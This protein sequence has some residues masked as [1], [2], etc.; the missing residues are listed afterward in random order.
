MILI[1]DN[2][3]SFTYNLYQQVAFT[4]VHTEVITN[5]Y[6]KFELIEKYNPEK[7]I[8]SSGP[9]TP[10][11][12][13]ISISVVKSYYTKI[14]IL[15]VC[16]GHQVIGVVFGSDIRKA[17][18]LLYGKTSTIHFEK[19]KL[20][21]FS[22]SIIK[23]ARYHSLVINKIPKGFNLTAWDEQNDIMGIEHIKY[24]I[25]GVQFHPESFMTKTGDKII[26]NFLNI[27]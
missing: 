25:F 26:Q 13:G 9:G 8:I 5:D 6:D 17:Q 2:Y 16:L 7:I 24:P 22:S 3:D 1:I 19:S 21:T 20:F 12:A 11:N 10:K 14:P 27:S 23:A 4:G 18:N 15:G